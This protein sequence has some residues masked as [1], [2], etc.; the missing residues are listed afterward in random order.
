MKVIDLHCDTLSALR[1]AGKEGK[2]KNLAANDQHID[3][4]KME[5]GDYLLQCFAAFVFLKGEEDPFTAALEEI[6]IFYDAMERFADRIAPV[7]TWADLEQNRAAGK[8][9]AMLTVEEGGVCKGN[10]S[11]LRTLYR[12]GARIMTLTWNFENELAWPNDIDMQTGLSTP[13]TDRG[14]KERGREFIA[15]MERLGMIVD[16][17][18]LGDAG[19]WDVAKTATR[20]FIATHSNARAVRGHVRNLTDEMLRAVADKG[21]VT[22]INFCG[23]FLDP[24]EKPYSSVFWMGEHIE[25]IRRV[26]GIEM[27]ALGSDFDGI[28]PDVEMGDCSGMPLLEAELHRRRF[29]DDEIEK[30]FHGNALRVLK[31]FL[32]EK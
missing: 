29:S 3:L 5:K 17:S 20:P 32:P 19:F 22:G 26:G 25:H 21:G 1:H 12:L 27:I 15:E 6:D 2:E 28:E 16:V 18:H 8:L 10:L 24:G 30:I 9:S 4:A 13:N 14:L 11:L 7:K 31:E 23:D